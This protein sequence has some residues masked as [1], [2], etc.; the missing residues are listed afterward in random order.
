ML[1]QGSSP[2]LTAGNCQAHG[3]DDPGDISRCP[4]PREARSHATPLAMVGPMAPRPERLVMYGEPSDIA[5]LDW[6]WVDA[7]LSAAGTYWVTA[8]G[9]HHPHPRPVWGVW[10]DEW[11][12]LSIG[13]PVIARLV[14]QHPDVT[15]HLD[16]GTDVVVLEGAV[17]GPTDDPAVI[18]AYNDKY[19]WNY[20]TDEFGPLTRIG[21]TAALAWR[22]AGRAGR[23][24]FRQAGRW[25]FE[26][27]P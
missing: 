11:L 25:R 27:A 19:D 15:V 2:D 20:T 23:D 1:P 12:N 7:E 18:R 10:V 5:P 24:G 17:A 22:S 14:E 3:S 6:A 13:S 21:P 9:G 4:A 8:S 26:P 16:S